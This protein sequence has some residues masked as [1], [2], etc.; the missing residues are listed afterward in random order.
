MTPLGY[1]VFLGPYVL[2]TG[3]GIGLP[4]YLDWSTGWSIAGG[5]MGFLCSLAWNIYLW[6]RMMSDR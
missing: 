3:L 2:L 4:I 6:S 5:I 1:L